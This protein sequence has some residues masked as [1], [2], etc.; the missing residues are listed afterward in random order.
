MTDLGEKHIMPLCALCSAEALERLC[1]SLVPMR[2]RTPQRGKS[3]ENP[4]PPKY[5][6]LSS[7]PLTGG[8]E[9]SAPSQSVNEKEKFLGWSRI[10]RSCTQTCSAIGTCGWR[11]AQGRGHVS[12]MV[13]VTGHAADKGG[14]PGAL[15]L[16]RRDVFPDRRRR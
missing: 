2:T 7:C 14:L 12:S 13:S 10:W 4:I 5:G 15:L 1:S 9:V 11:P 8:L 16:L 3:Q 6:N